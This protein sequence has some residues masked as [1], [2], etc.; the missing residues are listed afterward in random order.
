MNPSQNFQHCQKI[1]HT[2]GVFE[3][4][5]QDG[6]RPKAAGAAQLWYAL[7]QEVALMVM[8]VFIAVVM[9]GS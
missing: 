4:G 3:S 7:P 2:K 5:L 9:A 6:G 8:A 1:V